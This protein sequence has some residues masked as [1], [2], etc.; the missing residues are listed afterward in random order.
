M[1]TYEPGWVFATDF[2]SDAA[3]STSRGSANSRDV[4]RLTPM[5]IVTRLARRMLPRRSV[6]WR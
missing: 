6:I 5:E 2:I 3:A 4:D 1:A